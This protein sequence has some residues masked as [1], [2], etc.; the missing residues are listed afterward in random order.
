[1]PT[2]RYYHVQARL[3]LGWAMITSDAELARRLE[4]RARALLATADSAD[5]NAEE[6]AND[7][8]TSALQRWLD[9]FNNQQLWKP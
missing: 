3:L 5:K 9:E 8:M 7:E 6:A 4:E 2:S 1:M